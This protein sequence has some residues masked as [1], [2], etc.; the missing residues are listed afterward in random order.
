MKRIIIFII[1][2]SGLV[3]NG[4][5]QTKEKKAN[6]P[7][8]D[9]KVNREYD[10]QGNLIRFDSTY[11][12]NWSGDSTFLNEKLHGK[13]DHFLD[14]HSKFLNDSSFISDPFFD[15]FD[16]DDFDQ[17][18]AE[19]FSNKRDS[20]LMKK[21]GTDHF[22]FFNFEG[23]S[24]KGN[25]KDFGDFF[26]QM[27]P[28]KKDSISSGQQNNPWNPSAHSMQEMMKIMQHHMQ[29]IL[30]HQQQFFDKQPDWKEF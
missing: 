16:H 10:E 3:F 24:L 7:K 8:E 2:S 4:L 12:Y 26:G 20:L 29:E 27:K 30:K 6:S 21:F 15:D 28:D 22:Q 11:T 25:L 9:I 1:L 18:F 23:D 19:P 17:L 13:F 5:A 14:N